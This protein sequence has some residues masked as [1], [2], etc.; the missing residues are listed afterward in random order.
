MKKDLVPF[1]IDE[2]NNMLFIRF[3]LI[4]SFIQTKLNEIL[5]DCNFTYSNCA[6]DKNL[7]RKRCEGF[8]G[9]HVSNIKGMV[10]SNVPDYVKYF[11]A[12][13]NLYFYSDIIEI[14]DVCVQK[15]SR[16]KGVLNQMFTSIILQAENKYKLWLGIDPYN[17]YWDTVVHS[18]T[19]HGFIDPYVTFKTTQ[20]EDIPLTIAFYRRKEATPQ[21]IE[22]ARKI[23]NELKKSLFSP[24]KSMEVDYPKNTCTNSFVLTKNFLHSMFTLLVSPV[25]YGGNLSVID[26][27]LALYQSHLVEGEPK[28]FTVTY[29]VLSR[30]TF[31]T[32]PQAAYDNS[33]AYLG[34][35]SCLDMRNIFSFFYTKGMVLHILFTMEG[36]YFIHLNPWFQKATRDIG[37]KCREGMEKAIL[38]HFLYHSEVAET[39]RL[40][41]F[42]E[43]QFKN[44]FRF[45]N[46][47]TFNELLNH[48]VQVKKCKVISKPHILNKPIFQV[49]FYNWQDLAKP[50]L[51]K[52]T[53]H[54][55]LSNKDKFKNIGCAIPNT[56]IYNEQPIF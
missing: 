5:S 8:V 44:Y 55:Y 56:P 12:A 54:Y 28:T 21:E 1:I 15:T 30:I 33:K 25:E 48:D 14:Y 29:P 19:K 46:N 27:K 34:W 41:P 38:E 3:H 26:G 37:K 31:H 35:P 23:A 49:E 52:Y 2:A 10:E 36:I 47:F 53:Y 42:P 32:H 18:Y 13:C 24:A 17:P 50:D 51:F 11:D 39:N 20:Q 40:M 45:V 43:Q 4:P 6:V 7:T 9:I 22:T 16:N